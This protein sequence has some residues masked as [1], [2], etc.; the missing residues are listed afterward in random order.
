MKAGLILL[1]GA[2]LLVHVRSFL[3][4]A[5]GGGGGGGRGAVFVGACFVQDAGKL[6]ENMVP[7]SSVK[8]EG[9]GDILFLLARFSAAGAGPINYLL[10]GRPP[11]NEKAHTAKSI[12]NNTRGPGSTSRNPTPVT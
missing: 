7:A 3:L 12:H 2:C 10:T 8:S 9:A 11:P 1:Q 4:P 6:R 5:W